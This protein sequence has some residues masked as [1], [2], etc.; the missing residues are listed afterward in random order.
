MHVG[1]GHGDSHLQSHQGRQQ[2]VDLHCACRRTET[3]PAGGHDPAVDCWGADGSETTGQ[4]ASCWPLTIGISCGSPWA[5]MP[6]AMRR[7]D[8]TEPAYA[9]LVGQVVGIQAGDLVPPSRVLCLA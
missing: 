5:I 4:R 6:L 9:L 8:V 2:F 1:S 7:G 3:F